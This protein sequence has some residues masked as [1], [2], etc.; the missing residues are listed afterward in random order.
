MAEAVRTEPIKG[1]GTLW[2]Y[3]EDRD[4]ATAA[5]LALTVPLSGYHMFNVAAP[6]T[7]ASRP[8][9]ELF[10]QYFPDTPIRRPL[11]GRTTP[12]ETTPAT[13]ALGFTP[14]YLYP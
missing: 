1:A 8:T 5:W 3:L 10:A 4:A 6:E 13:A 7:F 2:T 12:V 11:P 9:E 14:E